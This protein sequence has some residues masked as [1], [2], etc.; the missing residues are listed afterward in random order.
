ML[1]EIQN[2]HVYYGQIHAV[3][4]V[5]LV[6]KQGEI[7]A[8]IGANGAGKSTTLLTIAGAISSLRGEI[9]LD[10]TP[11]TH[12]RMAE[13]A[14]LGINLVPEGR[15]IFPDFS[16]DEN[17]R[18][19]SYGVKTPQRIKELREKV[20]ALFPRLKERLHQ[21]GGTLSGGEQQMLAIARGLMTDPKI[22]LLDE[23]SLGLAPMV[24]DSI[25]EHI[26]E[27]HRQGIPVLLVEQNASLALEI[28]D[29]GY[30]METGKIVLEGP[31]QDLQHN[32]MVRHVYLG[33]GER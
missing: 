13:I 7:V 18:A 5:S 12:M 1:L 17:L 4:G 32:D 27:I 24:L 16:V 30:V 15:C 29:R 31:A 22:L 8:L 21:P 25:F 2:L 3:K 28:A 14:R 9:L 6:V 26:R 33:I 20:Y 23:P 10:E 11:I 19:G